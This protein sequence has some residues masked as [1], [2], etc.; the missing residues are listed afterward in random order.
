M[1][2]DVSFVTKKYN[3]GY[4]LWINIDGQK[5]LLASTLKNKREAKKLIKKAY[6]NS[7]EDISD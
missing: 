3:H 6:K 1:I 7:F 5:K 4:S 2:K